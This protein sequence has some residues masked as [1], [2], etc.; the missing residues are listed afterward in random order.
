MSHEKACMSKTGLA[1]SA[2]S[3]FN[4]VCG[5]SPQIGFPKAISGFDCCG[6]FRRKTHA[7]DGES[8]DPYDFSEAEKEMPQGE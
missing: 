6:Y 4:L 1:E 2:E 3:C 5:L 8:Y 7:K